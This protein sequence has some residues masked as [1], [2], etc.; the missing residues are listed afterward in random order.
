MR[1]F[2][3][4]L[5][6]N[7]GEIAC[8]VID[9]CRDLGLRTVAVFS[10]ADAQARHVTL[11][12]EA[13]CIGPAAAAASYL[14]IEAI[15]TAARRTGAD[16]I[17]PGY[18]FLAESA[19]FVERI[20]AE[21]GLMFIGPRASTVRQMGDK[22]AA[23][24]LMVRLGVPV[25]P[26]YDGD[27]QTDVRLAEEAQRIGF[28][29]LVK[30]SAGGGGK[31][32]RVVRDPAALAEALSAA[33]RVA[34]SAFGD[35]RLLLERYVEGPRHIEVQII[36]DGAGAVIHA[37]EREC[38]VQRRFQKIIEEAPAP[39]LDPTLRA[40][41]CAA[42]VR[43]GEG[44]NYLGLGTVEFIVDPDGRFYFLEI[45]TRLQVE[46]PVTEQTTGL[47]LVQLQLRLAQGGAL[48]PQAQLSQRDHAI[49]CRLYAEDPA[50]GFM[51]SS[52]LLREWRLPDGPGLRIDTGVVEG[53]RVSVHYDPLLAKLIAWGPDRQA[54]IQ[55]MLGALGRLGV[56][57]PVTNREF[58]MRVLR[59]RAFRAGELSTHFVSEHLA[60]P[61]AAVGPSPERAIAATLF[62]ALLRVAAR[63]TLPGL[64]AGWRNN[65]FRWHRA[66][67]HVGER[68]LV[69]EYLHDGGALYRARVNGAEVVGVRVEG[70]AK[71]E[72]TLSIAGLRRRHF[73][74]ADGPKR[75]IR[76]MS[77]A[78]VLQLAPRFP[79][80]ERVTDAGG[81]V[82]PMP[83][84]VTVVHVE[85]GDEVVA[86]EPL[87][88]LEAMKMEQQ[89]TAPH[90]GRVTK[91]GCAAGDLV[92]AGVVLIELEEG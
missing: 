67:W 81:C 49:E 74:R 63:P 20:E 43:A 78:D 48:P 3:R 35:D 13:V 36:G 82:A 59:H 52:G 30:A 88:V 70:A 53:D 26:G 64:R 8:R 27:E 86:G 50:A 14:N 66:V 44:L 71:G 77:G 10:E 62:D 73:I 18:G 54:A 69:V 51:P 91:V 90:S 23:R 57:G 89:L 1:R 5:V 83:G 29:V 58:L 4:V 42:A 75:W 16:A 68:P 2:E 33:R 40:E 61:V 19:E 32:M 38:S 47:D 24:Q 15:L 80:P 37:F 46:H 22:A 55:R 28:P 17:H 76:D 25:V 79:E 9:A 92:E 65:R 87:V 21:P 60:D 56:Q 72:L 45:N 7:R 85:L 6:A 11:A 41:L 12:D 34:A 39:N 31:G 84:L